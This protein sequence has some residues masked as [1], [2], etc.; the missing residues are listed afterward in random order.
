[1]PLNDDA[2]YRDTLR[3]TGEIPIVEA[4]GVLDEHG[5]AE[6]RIQLSRALA[7]KLAGRSMHHAFVLLSETPSS[8]ARRASRPDEGRL[9]R[10]DFVSNA[11]RLEVIPNSAGARRVTPP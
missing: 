1:L 5:Q 4:N 11:V 8:H 7:R 9:P 6:V 3:G 10:F 2:Y